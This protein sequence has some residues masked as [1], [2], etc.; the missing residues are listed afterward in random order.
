LSLREVGVKEEEDCLFTLWTDLEA[1]TQA[2]E[3]QRLRQEEE[4]KHPLIQGD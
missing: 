4:M 3:S 1:R 2:L